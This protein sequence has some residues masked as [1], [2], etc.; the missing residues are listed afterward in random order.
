MLL[1][2]FFQNTRQSNLRPRLR[3]HQQQQQNQT[4]I[5]STNAS[6]L[7][8]RLREMGGPGVK[9][10]LRRALSG[11]F[12]REDVTFPPLLRKSYPPKSS[13]VFSTASPLVFRLFLS[14]A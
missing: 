12:G 4:P 14:H 7:D 6:N 9:D 3:H 10:D 11:T 8:Q 1:L 5:Y 2:Y 13:V